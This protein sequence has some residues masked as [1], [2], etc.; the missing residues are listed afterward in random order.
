MPGMHPTHFG[1]P[2]RGIVKDRRCHWRPRMC[3]NGS[4]NGGMILLLVGGAIREAVDRGPALLKLLDIMLDRFELVCQVD[5]LQPEIFVRLQ[6]G[7]TIFGVPADAASTG[8]AV[9]ARTDAVG[10]GTSLRTQRLE[11]LVPPP[12]G[13]KTCLI[14]ALVR[15]QPCR[16][17]SVGPLQVLVG[18][19]LREAE[20]EI[21]FGGLQRIPPVL[22]LVQAVPQLARDLHKQRQKP[23]EQW[24]SQP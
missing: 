16:H 7:S 6:H 17:P 3:Y 13:C 22:G 9:A 14:P 10:T 8:L 20:E 24:C 4:F 12:H 18:G 21:V 5:E 11:S 19:I 23:M 1:V 2:H 15:V